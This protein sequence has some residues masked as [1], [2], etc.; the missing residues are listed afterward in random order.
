M[1]R[2]WRPPLSRRAECA[3]SWCEEAPLSITQSAHIRN[4]VAARDWCSD[5]GLPNNAFVS[6]VPASAIAVSQ[7][8]SASI[9]VVCKDCT[10]RDQV[11]APPKHISEADRSWPGAMFNSSWKRL[12]TARR[13]RRQWL[14]LSTRLGP[15]RIHLG[16]TALLQ[17]TLR[18]LPPAKDIV[19]ADEVLSNTMR[20]VVPWGPWRL[21]SILTAMPRTSF[22]KHV[23]RIALCLLA[24][25]PPT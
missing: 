15:P 1:I 11:R 14:V 10:L 21:F 2:R 16:G 7:P 22:V 25:S 8:V 6:G 5:E 4:A 20:Q 18:D 24:S 3:T 9:G 17:T 12:H 13:A 19:G 23:S